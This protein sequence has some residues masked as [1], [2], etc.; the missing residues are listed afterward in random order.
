MK[1][2]YLLLILLFSFNL[3]SAQNEISGDWYLFNY[4]YNGTTY[5]NTDFGENN[6]IITFSNTQGSNGLDFSGMVCN[7]HV[8]SYAI[9]EVDN[10]ISIIEM[11]ATL[12]GCYYNNT[13]DFEYD[14]FH[15]ILW[16]GSGNPTNLSY[17]I[18]GSVNNQ[19]LQLTNI[20]NSNYAIYGWIP[21]PPEIIGNWFLSSMEIDS[22][23]INN[24][25]NTLPTIQFEETLGFLG[26]NYTGN[27][28]C[29]EIS[30]E[31]F[32]NPQLTFNLHFASITLAECDTQE[33][34]SFEN[35]YFYDLLNASDSTE[36]DYE[37]TGTGD[38]A[39]LVIT[40]LTNGNKGFYGRQALSIDENQFNSSKI[41]L[42][43]NP[44]S[45]SLEVSTSQNLI[46][47]NYEI[48][49]ITGKRVIVSKLNSNSINVN[50]LHSGLYFLKV[51]T[52]ENVFETVKFIKD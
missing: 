28:A 14:Y 47:S 32:F 48:F 26:L 24:I 11:A 6:P 52:D 46:G 45:N 2:F 12:E 41:S 8:G 7:T 38:D 25:E 19:V 10:T 15:E 5:Y 4:N 16:D 42:D 9:N 49:S 18:T 1:Q 40:N 29:N 27:A 44:V 39:S 21:Q 36:F 20:E 50:Q 34:V 22:N 35:T 33:E 43:R 3:I 23:I 31:Y 13:E 30:G 37:I 17:N 51:S